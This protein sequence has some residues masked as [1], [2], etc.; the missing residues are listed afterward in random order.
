MPVGDRD[1]TLFA[2]GTGGY[3]DA[4]DVGRDSYPWNFGF[5]MTAPGR[6]TAGLKVTALGAAVVAEPQTVIEWETAAGNPLILIPTGKPSGAARFVVE[7]ADN[8]ST[9]TDSRSGQPYT[10]AVLYRHDGSS[11]DAEVA[12]FCNGDASSAIRRREKDATYG[13][14]V[15][16]AKA[17]LLAVVG[18]DLWRVLNKYQ[19]N[20]LVINT[21]PTDADN[22]SPTSTPAGHPAYPIR[23]V[24]ELGGA[25]W[26]ISGL[27]V[28]KYNPA[29]SVATFENQTPFVPAHKDNGKGAFTDGRGRI[30]YPTVTGRILVISFGSQS[31]QGPL[32]FNWID[33]DTPWGL[34]GAM[35]ADEEYIYAAIE[36]GALRTQQLGLSIHVFDGGAFTDETGDL[37]DQSWATVADITA[38]TA[39]NDYIYIGSDEPF[40]GVFLEFAVANTGTHIIFTAEYSTGGNTWQS[41]TIRD[42]TIG[43]T[44]DGCIALVPSTDIVQATSNPWLTDEINTVTNKYWIRLKPNGTMTSAKLRGAYVCPYRP[45]IDKDLFPETGQM[46]AGVLPKILRGQ[47]QGERIVWQ[48]WLTLVASRVL[49]III[50]RTSSANSVGPT[51]LYAITSASSGNPDCIFYVP[52][53]PQSDPVRAPWPLTNGATHAQGY[54]GNNFGLPVNVKRVQGKLVVHGGFLQADDEFY[55]YHHWDEGDRW[56]R[57]GPHHVFPV[58]V[59]GLEGRGRVLHVAVQLKDATRDAVAP[60]ITHAV[61]PEGEWTD[62]GP[63]YE[64]LG[65]DIASPQEM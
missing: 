38:L 14:G 53:G 5:D 45:P 8:A 3:G 49:N 28:F 2:G 37:T 47:W 50:G 31:Q 18:S 42:S 32:R 57:D 63:L 11:A 4:L 1:I 7:L 58:V 65:Q 24:L 10:S 19:L 59:E 20:K 61:I 29:P 60:H 16:T 48:D 21:D 27:G 64:A 44:R 41:V 36:P 17:D 56:Y 40:W 25:P 22:W 62:E 33:R 54:S 46:L 12:F 9:L 51:T 39:T 13:D 34:I 15:G 55:V 52:V 43:A 23:K 35:A 6:A 26:P 30:F